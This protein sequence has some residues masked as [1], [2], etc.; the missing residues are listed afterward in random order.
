MNVTDIASLYRSLQSPASAP[1]GSEVVQ[2][3][4]EAGMARLEQARQSVQ[5]QLS[6]YGQVKS[7]LE[8]LAEA[9]QSLRSEAPMSAAETKK[10]LQTMVSAYNETRAAAVMAEPGRASSAANA[11]RRAVSADEASADLRALGI[12]RQRDGALAIDEKKL[13]QALASDTA[14]TRAAA[15]R[16][17]GRLES[18]ASRALGESGGIGRTLQSLD[19]RLQQID[20]RLTG[21]QNLS[22]SGSYRRMASMFGA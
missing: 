8:R 2:K 21:L 15:G 12:T 9:G 6:A 1:A 16:F 18:V 3:A 13:D 11:L 22:G 5:V 17:A 19:Q 4:A 20:N 10:A 7:G 14:G